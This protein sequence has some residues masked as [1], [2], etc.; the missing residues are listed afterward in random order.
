VNDSPTEPAPL[1]RVVRGHPTDAELAALVAVVAVA[2]AA[3]V[4]ARRPPSAALWQGRGPGGLE[5]AVRVGW[6]ASA[7]PRATP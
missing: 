3:R 6:R 2:R 1:L 5:H 7:L 4:E